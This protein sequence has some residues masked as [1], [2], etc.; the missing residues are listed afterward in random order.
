[1]IDIDLINCCADLKSLIDASSVGGVACRYGFGTL[2]PPSLTGRE[3]YDIVR[4]FWSLVR[5]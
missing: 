1:M 4:C 2:L 3:S 5:P